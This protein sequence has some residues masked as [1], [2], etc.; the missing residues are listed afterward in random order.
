MFGFIIA[1]VAGFLTRHAE[2]PLTRPLIN[3]IAPHLTVEPGEVRLLSFIL[4]MLVAG[5]GAELLDSGSIFW[6][7]LGGATGYF[8]T[9]L[10][11][12]VQAGL[13]GRNS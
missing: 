8:A 11:A 5:I 2:D 10:L 6:V 1:L 13:K 12:A 7:I 4:V 3:R 9:R